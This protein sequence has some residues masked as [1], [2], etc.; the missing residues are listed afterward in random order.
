MEG[1]GPQEC[2]EHWHIFCPLTAG[3][4]GAGVWR[5]LWLPG[6]GLRWQLPPPRVGS[7]GAR[8]CQG[9][10]GARLGSRPTPGG[11]GAAPG[12]TGLQS[13]LKKSSEDWTS[14]S[15]QTPGMGRPW[16]HLWAPVHMGPLGDILH[17]A[18][19]VEGNSPRGPDNTFKNLEAGRD[20]VCSRTPQHSYEQGLAQWR[21]E[22]GEVCPRLE[23]NPGQ[24]EKRE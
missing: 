22:V 1:S 17:W 5:E 3:A 24:L 12:C 8:N 11:A 18:Q 14:S 23:K 13:E 16:G 15:L 2:Q 4:S 7:A 19:D 6:E 20:T 9:T 21:A 10:L